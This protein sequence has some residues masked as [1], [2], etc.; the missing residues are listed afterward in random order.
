MTQPKKTQPRKTQPKKTQRDRAHPTS[1]RK[2]KSRPP[3]LEFRGATKDHGEVRAVGPIDLSIRAGETVALLGHNGSGKST[4]FAMAAGILEPSEGE[5]KV[6]GAAAG[7]TPARAALSYVRDH[8]VLYED[9]SVREHLHYLSRL[10]GTDP[11]QH[12]ADRLVERLGLGHR[13]DDVP[14]S[15]SRGLRQKAA[16]AVAFCRPFGI[17]LV[18]EPFAGLDPAGQESLLS[19]LAEAADGGATV[20]VA[21]HDYSRLDHFGRA[22]VLSEGE[23]QYDGDPSELPVSTADARTEDEE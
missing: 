19:L 13:V 20:V 9:L 11:Q 12:D 15:F 7:D 2:K 23:L 8:P 17:L 18:D 10:H 6:F 1:K 3:A 22:V 4:L 21:T 14:A 5:V 16:L